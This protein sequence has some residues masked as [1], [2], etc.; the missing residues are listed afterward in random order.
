MRRSRSLSVQL[1]TGSAISVALGRIISEPSTSRT[2][3]ERMPM[4]RTSP[5]TLMLAI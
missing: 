3:L 1:V 2:V 4:R 5:N